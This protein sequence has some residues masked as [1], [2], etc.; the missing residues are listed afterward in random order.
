M[1]AK[2]RTQHSYCKIHYNCIKVKG[3]SVCFLSI[4][5]KF[6]NI[7]YFCKLWWLCSYLNTTYHNPSKRQKPLATNLY[8]LYE[9]YTKFIK[10][11]I[12]NNYFFCTIYVVW[13]VNTRYPSNWQNL[14]R[15]TY[16]KDIY[17]KHFTIC[18]LVGLTNPL[19]QI[20]HFFL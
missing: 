17:N 7:G 1:V 12:E 16:R 6:E 3:C 19:V 20:S 5:Q 4:Q 18:F 10:N 8:K 2:Q 14:L 15:P 11:F 9:L 13:I